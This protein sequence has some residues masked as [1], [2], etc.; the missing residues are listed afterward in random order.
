M[1][2]KRKHGLILTAPKLTAGSG[3]AGRSKS[4]SGPAPAQNTGPGGP[5]VAKVEKAFASADAGLRFPEDDKLH[6]VK[7]GAYTDALLPPPKLAGNARL[8]PEQKQAL[9]K[10]AQK[11]EITPA[12]AVPR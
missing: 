8:T 4:N 7:A 9:Q 6:I 12:Q 11:L 5:E 1:K 10:L 3:L 2:D